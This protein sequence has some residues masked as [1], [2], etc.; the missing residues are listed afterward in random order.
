MAFMRSNRVRGT[1][2]IEIL[3][4]IVIFLVGILA[5]AQIFPKGFR[6][7]IYGRNESVA[8][9]F[10]R[11]QVERL[12]E[13]ADQLPAMIVSAFP[14][15][16]GNLV[17]DPTHNPNSLGPVGDSIAAPLTL[18]DGSVSG[19]FLSAGGNTLGD[20]TRYS[21]ANTV[22]HIIG[23]GRIVP[24][25]RLVG[26]GSSMYG[27]LVV[28]N[29]GPVDFFVN[30]TATPPT[31]SIN[32][33]GNDLNQQ[34]G[35]PPTGYTHSDDEYFVSN[36][37]NS[38]ISVGLPAGPVTLP[39]GTANAANARQY[40]ISFSA[41]VLVN[42][43]YVRR[44]YAGLTASVPNGTPDVN[45]ILPIDSISIQ[46][47][48]SGVTLGSVDI[49]T[50][51]VRRAFLQIPVGGDWNAYEPY[52][53]KLL[54][55]SL[56]VILFSPSAFGQT[57]SG[58][59][60]RVPLQ[61]RIDYDVYD[62]RIIREEFRFPSG[63]L[64]QHQLALGAIKIGHD[65]NS[66]IPG[67]ADFDGRTTT[68]I[69]PLEGLLSDGTASQTQSANVSSA[70]N[71]VLMDLDTGGVYMEKNQ[72]APVD[73]SPIDTFISVNKSTGLITVRDLDGTTSGTQANLLLPDGTLLTNVTI[74]NRAVRALYVP[75]TEYSV[76]V[77]KAPA[78]YMESTVTPGIGQ[79]AI[80]ANLSAGAA[81]A[82]RIYFPVCDVGRKVSAGIINYRRS[83]DNSP[84]QLHNQDFVIAFPAVKDSVGLPCIDVT[85]IDP[86]ATT[87]DVSINSHSFGY[88]VSTVKGD[89]VAVRVLWNPGYFLLGQDTGNDSTGNIYK[90]NTWGQGWRQATNETYL[91][92]GDLIP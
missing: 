44:D 60:G 77:L 54:N 66:A 9:Q 78:S 25:P 6:I 40:I 33:Y 1:T 3:V 23:E 30:N 36:P 47:L 88:A 48:L 4:V 29:F 65:P 91:E 52:A 50:L 90:V 61:A 37:Q 56:G 42:N 49:G 28:L 83:S 20:W 67:Q 92:Q 45:G 22:R 8:T 27:G 55:P 39:S 41:Y 5:V 31:N 79:F 58:P 69:G 75:K 35:L 81:S 13:H 84:R 19:G 2:L 73:A 63:Q 10:A 16:N 24:A 82:T 72:T 80:G 17:I 71:F 11:D 21:G 86:Q 68:D 74:D 64:A 43:V 32:V 70:N 26:T 14:D 15:A 57:I 85:S 62:W 53:C 12:E 51:R 46:S 18:S 87:L 89:S 76:Q 7:L 34:Q 59:S 38:G